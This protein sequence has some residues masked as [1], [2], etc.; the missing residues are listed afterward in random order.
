MPRKTID[1]KR[2]ALLDK[3]DKARADFERW[4]ARLKRAFNRMEQS[5]RTLA[6]LQRQLDKLDRLAG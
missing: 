2:I 1:P 3:A 5:R 4:Y 6:R